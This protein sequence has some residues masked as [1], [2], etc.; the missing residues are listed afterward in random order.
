MDCLKNVSGRLISWSDEQ[1][2]S[3]K[4]QNLFKFGEI[5]FD[6]LND[7]VNDF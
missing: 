2:I 7:V 3:E 5:I 4:R 6:N 1:E